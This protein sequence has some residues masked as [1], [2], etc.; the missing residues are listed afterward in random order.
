[1]IKSGD[2]QA[3]AIWEEYNKTAM[4]AFPQL[5]N[6]DVDNIIAYTDFTT[7]ATSSLHLQPASSS[8]QRNGVF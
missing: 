6:E 5:S 3:I 7:T 2:A 1:M 4:T 8:L